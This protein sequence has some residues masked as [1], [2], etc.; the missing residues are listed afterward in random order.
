M[1]AAKAHDRIKYKKR[2]RSKERALFFSLAFRKEIW[3]NMHLF[4]LK[5]VGR[6]DL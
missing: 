6:I 2:A 4:H 3:D 5:R 1:G